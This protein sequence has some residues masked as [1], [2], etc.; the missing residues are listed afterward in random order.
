MGCYSPFA[1][2]PDGS[3]LSL[4]QFHRPAACVQ[5]RHFMRTLLKYFLIILLIVGVVGGA[6]GGVW[7]WISRAPSNWRTAPVEEGELISVVNS[8]GTIKPTQSVT[9]GAFVSGPVKELFCEFNQEVKKGDLLAKIDP[10]IYNANVLRDKA[11]LASREAD[12]E[13]AQATL[14]QAINDEKRGL[15]LRAED[16]TF[17]SQQEMDK[18]KFSRMSLEAQVLSAKTAVEQARGSLENSQ[19]SLDYTNIKAPVDGIVINRKIDPGQT[20]A[21]QFQTP[22]LFI[23]APDMRKTMHVHASVDEADIGLI[24]EARSKQLP[25]TFTVDA[26]PDDLFQGKIE[27][28]RYSSTTTQNVVTYPVIVS[29]GNPDLKLFP[30]MTASISFQVGYKPKGLK[31]PNA[32]LRFFPIA[33]QVRPED[34]HLVEG[35]EEAAMP[36]PTAA[37]KTTPAP[38]SAMERSARR[39]KRNQRHVWIEEGRLLRAIPVTVGIS[40]SQFTALESGDVKPGDRLIVGT[41]AKR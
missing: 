29:S 10:L 6:S 7:Y 15:A 21:S 8:T 32:A 30:G 18:L 36:S 17:I 14:Q 3:R 2:N 40:D 11:N 12:V 26:Y 16:V 28:I 37:E 33:S 20:V 23:I 35:V 5:A 25:V 1:P 34:K 22:E 41:K 39:K 19:A 24:S 4:G 31:V 27:E 13:R 38:L 9:V